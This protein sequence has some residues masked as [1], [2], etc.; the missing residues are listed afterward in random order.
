MLGA[1]ERLSSLLPSLF[2]H[3]FSDI[4][5]SSQRLQFCFGLI[6]DTGNLVSSQASTGPKMFLL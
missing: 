5:G 3:R 4:A 6:L 1:V 2:Q